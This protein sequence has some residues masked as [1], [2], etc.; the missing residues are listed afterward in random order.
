MTKLGPGDIYELRTEDE[1]RRHPE[2]DGED[3]DESDPD[4]QYEWPRLGVMDE[5]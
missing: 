1:E 2:V 3:I 4:E 5:Q